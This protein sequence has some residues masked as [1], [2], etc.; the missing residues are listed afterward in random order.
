MNKRIIFAILILAAIAWLMSH[1]CAP[2]EPPPT[3]TIAG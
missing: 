3:P 1:P 2:P